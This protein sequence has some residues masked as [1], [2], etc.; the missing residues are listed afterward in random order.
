MAFVF[1]TSLSGTS[2]SPPP[3]PAG[4]VPARFLFLADLAAGG[5]SPELPAT[6][7]G[8]LRSSALGGPGGPGG[9]TCRP[10]G[11]CRVPVPWEGT[12][13][14]PGWATTAAMNAKKRIFG[15]LS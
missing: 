9:G 6:G 10:S 8:D 5:C 11:G 3:L 12:V 2:S 4:G 13:L 7:E 14:L 1:L 15:K